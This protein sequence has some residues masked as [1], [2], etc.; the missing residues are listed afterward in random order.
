MG[1]C[2]NKSQRNTSH[3]KIFAENVSKKYLRRELCKNEGRSRKK[4][5]IQKRTAFPPTNRGNLMTNSREDRTQQFSPRM[6]PKN[7]LSANFAKKEGQSRPKPEMKKRTAFPVQE[8]TKDIPNL[9]YLTQP[10]KRSK[11]AGNRQG[12]RKRKN[13]KK[14]KRGDG[15][16]TISQTC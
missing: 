4:T 8:E 3:T 14:T 12:E 15:P 6:C 2:R 5:R 1:P 13:K 10:Q 16:T 9:D 11:Q 7:I